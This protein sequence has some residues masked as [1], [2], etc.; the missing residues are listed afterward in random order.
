MQIRMTL[1]LFLVVTLALAGC[2]GGK[3][4]AAT[5]PEATPAVEAATESTPAI[6]STVAPEPTVEEEAEAPTEAPAAE[7][8][9]EELDLGDRTAGLDQLQ[10]YRLRWIVS[11]EKE[12]DGQKETAS[13]DLTQEHVAEPRA[14]HVYL[15]SQSS[16]DQETSVF[17]TYNVDG[18]SYI[19]GNAGGKRTCVSL[20]SDDE[21]TSTG[22]VDPGT[23]GSPSEARYVGRE[24]VNGIA[25]R[26][27]TY[28]EKSLALFGASK[29]AGEIWV[30]VDGGYVV[31]ETASW[32]GGTGFLGMSDDD[33][34]G[35]GQWTWELTDINQPLSITAPEDCAVPQNDLPMLADAS[36]KMTMGEIIAY[37]TQSTLKEA[38]EFYQTEMPAA[39]WKLEG[40]PTSMEDFV[41]L[42]FKK[43]DRTAQVMITSNDDGTQV[44]IN[45][46]E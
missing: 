6:E 20:S 4:P 34:T 9:E 45:T 7:T 8:D 11:W 46:G 33:G 28:D 29:V 25:T 2:G 23:I 22:P 38:S 44:M 24:T 3:T 18:M 41:Q 10:S 21:E 5:G 16:N 37:Q 31:K 19:V 17:E 26:H 12:K 40:E 42:T 13:L 27:Y 35:S 30:A 14:E 39:G 43:D 1:A 15:N 36:D 32:E